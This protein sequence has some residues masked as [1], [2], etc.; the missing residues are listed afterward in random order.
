MLM[1]SAVFIQNLPGLLVGVGG[2]EEG[3]TA[4]AHAT[5]TAAYVRNT[6]VLVT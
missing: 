4:V 5:L 6:K 2:D 3:S 1:L